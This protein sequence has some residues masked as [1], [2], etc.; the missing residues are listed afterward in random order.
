MK[1]DDEK[2]AAAAKRSKGVSSLPVSLPLALQGDDDYGSSK[3]KATSVG[4]IL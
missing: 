1:C 2:Q 4:S 3:E